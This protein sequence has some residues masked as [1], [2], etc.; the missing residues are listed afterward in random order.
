MLEIERNKSCLVQKGKKN[1]D[2]DLTLRGGAL[3]I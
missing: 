3:K 1:K 2:I